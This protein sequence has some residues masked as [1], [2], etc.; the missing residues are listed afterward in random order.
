MIIATQKTRHHYVYFV[1]RDDFI[2]RSPCS[3]FTAPEHA[4]YG[5]IL[6]PLKMTASLIHFRSNIKPFHGGNRV[7]HT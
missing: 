6:L 3:P 2:H 1:S 5:P 4:K 7:Q